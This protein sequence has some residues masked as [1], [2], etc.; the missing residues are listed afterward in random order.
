MSRSLRPTI[1]VL[2]LMI[3]GVAWFFRARLRDKIRESATLANDAPGA[4]VVEDMIEQATDPRA[5]LLAAWN[6][7]K[8]VHREVAIGAL[9]RV[10]PDDQPLPP[11]F[12]SILLSAAL[13]PDM[14]VR[15]LAFGILRERD[16]PALAELAA[17]Q[18]RDPD[19]QVR[20][21]GLKYL[22]TASPDV[23]VPFVA[24]L[25][26]EPDI[27]VLGMS[28]KL[29][30]NW[31]GE[32]FGAKLSD[33]V[34]VEDKTSGLLE[35]QPAGVAQTQAAAGKAR[36]WWAEH[37]SEFRPVKLAVPAGAY[38]ALRQVPEADFHL[39][40]LSGK[41]VRLSD[42]RGKVV[43]IN[44]WTTW[45][46]ACVGEIPALEALKQKCGDKLVILGVSLDF[47]PDE[48]GRIGSL[49]AV[50]EQGREDGEH[51]KDESTE[52]ALKRVRERV[53]RTVKARNINYPV[54]LDESNEVG[55]C[56]NGGEL[57]T[58]VIVDARGCV[59]RRFVGARGLPVLEAMIAEATRA[60][61]QALR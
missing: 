22:G 15:E 7:G 61:L 39:P 31:S 44:F 25:L 12:E 37:K 47:A 10:F 18:L 26:N 32:R 3:L 46:T 55:G 52:A 33:T 24:G 49:A 20:L 23:G 38:A 36:A 27:A 58:T 19:Q 35:F 21:L 50:E 30:E 53:A 42:Y 40:T 59:R 57:P 16:H 6:S 54:L 56:Y 8:I 43:L 4:G 28:V 14:D 34:Q 17:E 45:C 9:R 60:P 1:L 29:L 41:R 11:E 2:G 51:P 48:D 13:D 5:A